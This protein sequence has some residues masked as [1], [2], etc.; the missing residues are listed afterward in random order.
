MALRMGFKQALVS[1]FGFL[2]RDWTTGILTGIVFLLLSVV[3]GWFPDGLTALLFDKDFSRAFWMIAVSVVIIL[4]FIA[5][6]VRYFSEVEF[7][8]DEHA[9]AKKKALIVFLSNVRMKNDELEG[10]VEEFLES[11]KDKELSEAKALL[12]KSPMSSW[13]MVLEALEYHLPE[14]ERLIVLASKDSYPQIKSFKKI[15]EG[16]LKSEFQKLKLDEFKVENFD[17]VEKVF[18]KLNEVYKR[19]YSY[20]LKDRNIIIDVTGG[21]KPISIAGALMTVVYPYREFQ[22]VSSDKNY[23]NYEVKSY[24]VRLLGGNNI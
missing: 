1:Q 3:A 18:N 4:G 16:I 8:I 5:F 20:G 6:G 22:Y 12:N 2:F 15:A 7:D 11:I 13:R 9:P 14:L 19:L 10:V 23:E 17:D 21:R 24:D